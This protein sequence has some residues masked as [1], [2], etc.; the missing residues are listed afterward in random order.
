MKNI[1]TYLSIVVLAL[2]GK[3]NLNVSALRLEP[4]VGDI[5]ASISLTED[6][7]NQKIG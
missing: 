2:L 7:S 6:L 1:N 4:K 3:D 5:P